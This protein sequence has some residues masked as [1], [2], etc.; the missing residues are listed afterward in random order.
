MAAGAIWGVP[1]LADRIAEQ[2]PPAAERALGDQ[3]LAS[4]DRLGLKV[5]ALEAERR[6]ELTAR[7]D[8]LAQGPGMH[9][10]TGS[11]SAMRPASARTR[12]RCR[13]VRSSSLISSST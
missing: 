10:A 8:K 5:S 13:A 9:R 6:D 2:I 3:V 7:F 12:S 11:N 4:L 1:W